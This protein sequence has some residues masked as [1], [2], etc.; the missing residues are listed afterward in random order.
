MENAPCHSSHLHEVPKRENHKKFI[1]E[2]LLRCDIYF[3][4][5]YSKANFLWVAVAFNI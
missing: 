4:E 3:D 1:Q 2:Y 5:I